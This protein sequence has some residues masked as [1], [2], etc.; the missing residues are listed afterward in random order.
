MKPGLWFFRFRALERMTHGKPASTSEDQGNEDDQVK[1]YS[2]SA[3]MS[4]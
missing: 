1:R 3:V 4:E 2:E